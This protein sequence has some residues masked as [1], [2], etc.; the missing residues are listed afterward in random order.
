MVSDHVEDALAELVEGTPR[1]L[2]WA[3]EQYEDALS[4]V[5]SRSLEELADKEKRKYALGMVESERLFRDRVGGGEEMAGGGGNVDEL[6][7]RLDELENEVGSLS[8]TVNTVR[9]E[10]E[11]ISESVDEVEENVRK[12]LDIYEMVTRGVNPFADDIDAGMGGMAE[13]G[14]FGLFDD[15]GGGGEEEQLDEDIAEA[16]AEGFFDDDLVEDEGMSTDADVDDVLG[17]SGGGSSGGGADF[18]D[19]FE[20]GFDAGGD[21][22]D[23]SDVG[24]DDDAGGKS[25]A[26]L[27]DEYESGEAD[28][29][30]E[31]DTGEEA[32][33]GEPAESDADAGEEL[34]NDEAIEG[35]F[36]DAGEDFEG[37]LGDD[38]L[39]DEVIEESDDTADAVPEAPAETAATDAPEPEPSTGATTADA[40]A[41]SRGAAETEADAAD[42]GKPYI[43]TL[44]DGFAAELIVVEWL[45]F[46]VSEAGVRETARAIDYYED[47]DWIDEGVAEDLQSYLRGFE[48]GG[49][50]TLTIDH[51]T[52]SLEFIGQLNG[53][54]V[55]ASRLHAGGGAD[56]LQR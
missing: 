2:D 48:G 13:D 55:A 6:E 1:S 31:E 51:H 28:W 8:S 50:G 20:D 10:N 5:E 14:S 26:E 23:G 56:G 9:N 11:Q 27:K 37:D 12:L 19:S 41:A 30:E 49:D 40:A 39:F 35:D 44:P 43:G 46:L 25:F 33:D 34:L 15:D 18:E 36:D 54:A 17:D 3:V 42:D 29:A 4:D 7:H 45:E 32:T 52:Q 53:D 16:D 38:D 22:L 24:G 21:D 47:I